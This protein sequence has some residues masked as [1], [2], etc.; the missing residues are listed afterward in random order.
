VIKEAAAAD[1]AAVLEDDKYF[2]PN[3]P[4]GGEGDF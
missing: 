3:A 1:V 2:F 4:G